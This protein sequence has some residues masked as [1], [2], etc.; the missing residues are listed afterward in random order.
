MADRSISGF[1]LYQMGNVSIDHE[2]EEYILFDIKS[3][4]EIYPVE[5]EKSEGAWRCICTDYNTRH[6]KAPGSFLCKHIL[7]ALFK[8]AELKGVR[9]QVALDTQVKR[10][11][12]S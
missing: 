9:S 10:G 11:V 5:Y 3:K 4:K 12:K 6:L 2:D 8:L 7:A 1:K